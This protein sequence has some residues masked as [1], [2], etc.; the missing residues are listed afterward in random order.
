VG[1]T[2]DALTIQ[3]DTPEGLGG[4]LA[5]AFSA[6]LTVLEPGAPFYVCHADSTAQT[7]AAALQDLG[8]VIRQNLVW[9]KNTMVLGRSDYQY[10]HE[11]IMYGF[12]PGGEGRLGRGGGRWYG[13]HSQ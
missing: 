7:F 1:K 12:A 3:G 11:P 5:A 9:V 6:A 2:E 4:L 8:F 13:D 10:Q